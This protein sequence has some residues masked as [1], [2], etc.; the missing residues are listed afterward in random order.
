[1]G[2]FSEPRGSAAH[3]LRPGDVHGERIN[4][5]E[6]QRKKIEAVAITIIIVIINIIIIFVII[7]TNNIAIV[8]TL[9]LLLLCSVCFHLAVYFNC[10]VLILKFLRQYFFLTL[11]VYGVGTVIL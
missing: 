7:I 9:L 8:I 11:V 10:I 1:M 2:S 6:E 5:I 3:R 4:V